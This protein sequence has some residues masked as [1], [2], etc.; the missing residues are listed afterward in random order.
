MNGGGRETGFRFESFIGEL[1]TKLRDIKI[2]RNMHHILIVRRLSGVKDLVKST[3]LYS[4]HD[5]KLLRVQ[6]VTVCR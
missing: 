5:S 1:V 4:L 2:R 3:C 6:P